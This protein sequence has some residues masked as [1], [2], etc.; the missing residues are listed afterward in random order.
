[1]VDHA[2]CDGIV[3]ITTN[4]E[5]YPSTN[6]NA[7]NAYQEE[8]FT[9]TRTGLGTCDFTIAYAILSKFDSAK[10]NVISIPIRV[11]DT[12]DPER[13]PNWTLERKDFGVF[14][15]NELIRGIFLF[16]VLSDLPTAW[17]FFRVR[18]GHTSGVGTFKWLAKWYS[19]IGGWVASLGNLAIA[20]VLIAKGI[21][22]YNESKVDQYLQNQDCS[23]GGNDY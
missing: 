4:I 16:H 10:K 17:S 7:D 22:D 18:K 11:V 13:D 8:I 15:W 9:L 12:E 20:G 2:D 5:D 14:G 6:P 19:G 1:M 21:D 3:D 23:R